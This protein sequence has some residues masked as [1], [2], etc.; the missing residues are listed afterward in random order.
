MSTSYVISNTNFNE[1][2]AIASLIGIEAGPPD[3]QGDIEL[4]LPMDKRHALKKRMQL[5]KAVG[6]PPDETPKAESR[7]SI[8][9]TNAPDKSNAWFIGYA[10]AVSNPEIVLSALMN[11]LGENNELYSEHDEMYRIIL[12]EGPDEEF[13]S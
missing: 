10:T 11:A 1:I 9:L 7:S 6:V 4:S 12:G 5:A 2:M 13:V 3:E 8:S